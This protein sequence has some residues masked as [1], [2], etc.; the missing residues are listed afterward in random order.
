M[1]VVTVSR[2]GLFS[3]GVVHGD[4]VVDIAELDPGLP[5]SLRELLELEGGLHRLKELAGAVSSTGGMPLAEVEFG[6]VVP[7]PRAIWCAALTF[8]SH[9]TEAPGRSAPPYP[10]FFL[11]VA[12]SQTGHRCPL[13]R[14]F[15]SQQLDYEGELALIIG[16]PARHVP[17]ERALEFVAGY[18]CYNDASVRDWQRH[19][20]EISPGK[21]F[22][23]TGAF[24]PWLVT[25]DEFG[26]PYQHTITTRVNGEVRQQD[27][28]AALLF[29]I[30]YLIHYLS[31]IHTLRPGDV[32]VC[33]TP[34]GVGLRRHPPEFLEPGDVVTVEIDGIGT[35][36]NPVV[37]E[38]SGTTMPFKPAT[39]GGVL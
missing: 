37:A 5:R 13:I 26:D 8:G 3:V 11:R 19:T 12:E 36:E 24:G 2:A 15:V 34:G 16:R 35:L 17:V 30:Q 6:P 31:T 23:A 27:S 18:S 1:R 28:I 29:P 32:V 21:N 14:P 22:A 7:D 10:L 39:P 20:S 9:V 4:R 25:P 38:I 33:G